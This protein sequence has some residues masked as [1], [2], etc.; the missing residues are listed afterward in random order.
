MGLGIKGLELPE[1]MAQV[2][3]WPRVN[4]Y[5]ELLYVCLCEEQRR[6]AA[7]REVAC[8]TQSIQYILCQRTHAAQISQCH[9]SPISY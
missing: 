2:Q 3:I 4:D 1:G 5:Q 7:A 9:L 6:W 8:W